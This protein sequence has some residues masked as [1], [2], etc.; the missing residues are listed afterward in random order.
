MLALPAIAHGFWYSY[1]GK[2]LSYT[3]LDEAT[4]TCQVT[5]G[6][7]V[8]G[9]LIIPNAVIYGKDEYKVT[10]INNGAFSY[11][12]ELQSIVIPNSVERIGNDA[13]RFCENLRTVTLSKSLKHIGNEAFRRCNSLKAFFLPSSVTS[14]G[15]GPFDDC[16]SLETIEV[17]DKN[18]NFVSID[19]VLF[20]KN[21]ETL[22]QFPAGKTSIKY[23]IPAQVNKI[24]GFAF[25]GCKNL[26]SVE[27][28]DAVSNIDNAAFYECTGIT[29]I[30]IPDH[31][32]YVGVNAFWGC[33]NLKT[34]ESKALI[35]PVCGAVT[36]DKSTYGEGV[37]YVSP[38][39]I[40]AYE[41]ADEWKNFA[42]IAIDS[43][44]V[45][46]FEILTN[47]N[48]KID[49]VDGAIVVNGAES[50][51][52]Y[53]TSGAQVY[54]GESGRIELPSGIYLVVTDSVTKKVHI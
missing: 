50:V 8:S 53:N 27:I 2:R 23:S 4:K 14:L 47:K 40:A 10:E 3:I 12:D 32:T 38:D 5:S 29:S 26:L 15:Y 19:G 35:P 34:V 6:Q 7:S 39:A 30:K 52:I 43:D 1:E 42:K 44:L 21:L 28:P 46:N 25:F 20:D 13:F 48:T 33:S 37:L 49:V 18:S 9:D 17:D 24:G 36:F 11:C 54:A 31:V 51:R 22:I 45:S 16:H 41:V